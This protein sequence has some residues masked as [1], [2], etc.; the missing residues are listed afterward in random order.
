MKEIG[1]EDV[2]LDEHC[3]VYGFIP[4]T[5]ESLPTLGFIFEGGRFSAEE[6]VLAAPLLLAT[7]PD[8]ES[9]PVAMVSEA[10]LRASVAKLV[11]FGTR[12]TL[13][14]QTDRRRGIG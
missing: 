3:Y 7:A 6:T 1:L 8:P 9:D 14:S 13:S 12:H 4:A 10:E 2:R 5:D 11:S